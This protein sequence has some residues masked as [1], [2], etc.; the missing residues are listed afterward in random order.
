M[1]YFVGRTAVAAETAF[2]RIW[3][4]RRLLSR[5]DRAGLFVAV[6]L[7]AAA[8][9]CSVQ[10]PISLGELGTN[11]EANRRAGGDWRLADSEAALAAL[12][13]FFLSA[14]SS[15]SSARTLSTAR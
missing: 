10:I 11:M 7:M 9:W 5:R 4:V 1:N 3:A 14:S 15:M 13:A 6:M 12:A 8:A 2:G